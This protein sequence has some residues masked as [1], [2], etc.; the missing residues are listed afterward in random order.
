MLLR[1]ERSAFERGHALWWPQGVDRD[2][3]QACAALL[4]GPHDFTAF[5]PTESD[6]VRFR[7]EV[8]G[9]AWV[10]EEGD[11]L[12]F[13][14][15]ADAFLRHMNRVLVGT[16][17]EVATGRRELADFAALLRGRPARRGR[18]DGPA[19]RAPPGR[20]ALLTAGEVEAQRDA[21]AARAVGLD[22]QGVRHPRPEDEP[23]A[24]AGAVVARREAAA[25]V[26]DHDLQPP[27]PGR[28]PDVEDARPAVRGVGVHD[29]VREDLGDGE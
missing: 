17:L 14:I 6:H 16:M 12:A 22:P 10:E 23:E 11:V 18:A 4:P 29:D 21:R 2:A 24:E 15:E 1:P 13:W 3:L 8:F 26:G 28:G 20:R 27:V 25:L 5:T 19:A 7:R 9:A